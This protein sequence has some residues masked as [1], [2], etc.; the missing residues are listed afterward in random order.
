MASSAL[1][2]GSYLATPRCVRAFGSAV[3]ESRL[4][5]LFANDKTRHRVRLLGIGATVH[6]PQLTMMHSVHVPADR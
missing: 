5:V 4:K 1:R 3:D 6:V 2:R